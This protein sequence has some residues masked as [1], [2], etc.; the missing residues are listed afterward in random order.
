ME[1]EEKKKLDIWGVCVIMLLPFIIVG[2]S[3]ANIFN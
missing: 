2:L 3:I 1:E